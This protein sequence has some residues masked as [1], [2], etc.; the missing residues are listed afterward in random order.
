MRNWLLNFKPHMAVFVQPCPEDETAM[1]VQAVCADRVFRVRHK[2]AI[3]NARGDKTI[4]RWLG[5]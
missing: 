4:L 5:V 2:V 1:V 3:K